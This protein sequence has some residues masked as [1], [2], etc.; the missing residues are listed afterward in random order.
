MLSVHLLLFF[1]VWKCFWLHVCLCSALSH[2]V[3]AKN[4]SG[5]S[6][7]STSALN[8]WAISPEPQNS[9]TIL[10]LITTLKKMWNLSKILVGKNA[11]TVQVRD[12]ALRIY[13]WCPRWGWLHSWSR[14][15]LGAHC[16]PGARLERGREGEEWNVPVPKVHSQSP[17]TVSCHIS[18]VGAQLSSMRSDSGI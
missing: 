8:F 1:S 7:Y 6:V 3:G 5:S 12:W 9:F 4:E 16:A 10:N 18:K 13:L 15:W 2:H 17:A 11:F 14:G